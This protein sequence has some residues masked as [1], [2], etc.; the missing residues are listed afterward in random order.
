MNDFREHFDLRKLDER[1]LGMI[2]YVLNSPAYGDTFEPYLRT[3]RESLNQLWLDRSQTRKDQYPDDF[4]A[5]GIAMID[6]LLKFFTMLV[7]ETQQERVQDA[8]ANMSG[9]KYYEHQRQ[10][11]AVQPVVGINQQSEPDVYRPEEDY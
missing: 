8:L 5:G 10:R 6:G 1:Q 3:V 9:D 4:L 11:G 7:A 2:E